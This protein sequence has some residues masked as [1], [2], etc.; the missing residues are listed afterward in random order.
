MYARGTS[1]LQGRHALIY[2]PGVQWR[3]VLVLVGTDFVGENTMIVKRLL[4]GQKF[5]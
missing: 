5:T 1:S 2:F 4:Y 3:K